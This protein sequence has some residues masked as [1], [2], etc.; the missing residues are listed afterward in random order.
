MSREWSDSGSSLVSE[1]M[2]H[3]QSLRS[4]MNN[5]LRGLREL[6]LP[7]LPLIIEI[8][9]LADGRDCIVEV[10]ILVVPRDIVR[11]RTSES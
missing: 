11:N 3:F 10:S 1:Q 5:D 9:S 4:R 2:N 8:L 6:V 7:I